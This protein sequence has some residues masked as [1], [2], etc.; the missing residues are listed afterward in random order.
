MCWMGAYNR[1]TKMDEK[2]ER[3]TITVTP[4]MRQAVADAAAEN[5]RSFSQMAEII[6]REGL[7]RFTTKSDK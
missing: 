3:I 7:M 5:E 2:K 4:E 1:R 6:M